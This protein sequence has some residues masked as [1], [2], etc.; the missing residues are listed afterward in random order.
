MA[1]VRMVFNV[2][3]HLLAFSVMVFIW[4]LLG[5]V[6]FDKF[7]PPF[8]SLSHLLMPW[9]GLYIIPFM[10]TTLEER[11][12]I[13]QGL[14]DASMKVGDV[15]FFVIIVSFALF[16]VYLTY[17]YQQ[18]QRRSQENRML[19]IKNQEISRRNEFIRYISATISHEFKNNLGRVKR[20]ID[21]IEGLPEDT[22]RQIE[23]NFEKLFADIEIFKKIAD[24]RE[25]SLIDFTMVNLKDMFKDLASQYSDF[26]EITFKDSIETTTI[27]ASKSLLRTVFETLIDNAIK[28]KKPKQ[29][30]AHITLSCGMDI[31]AKRRYVTLSFRDEGI[32][33]DDEQADVC[34]YKG[35]G[36]ISGWGEGL[37]FA[38]YVIGLHAGKIRVGKEYTAPDLGMEIIIH[39]PFVEESLNV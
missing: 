37:Y 23:N 36:S 33:M 24:E 20:R 31:D 26:A 6:Y 35:K 30:K 1:Y 10:S 3:S 38:K 32:G 12:A 8:D 7:I 29:E 28:Y 13:M 14:L 25:A 19:L 9:K 17:V 15:A 16:S 18:R 39:L 5:M 22:R 4:L 21:L 2:F 34:F 27:F 11:I